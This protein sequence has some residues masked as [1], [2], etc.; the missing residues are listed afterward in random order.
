MGLDQY[1]YATKKGIK[2]IEIA[3]WRKH[4][5]LE[6]YMAEIY[7]REED[8]FATFN[9]KKLYVHDELLDSLEIVINNNELHTYGYN[10]DREACLAYRA[11]DLEFCYKAKSY[12][13]SGYRVFYTS[14]W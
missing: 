3:Y 4:H 5:S 12:L 9:C 7:A 10:E 8:E 13:E 6:A 11:A 1:A 2:S 14:W